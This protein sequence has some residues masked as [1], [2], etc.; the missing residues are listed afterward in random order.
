MG[1][2]VE[3]GTDPF[4]SRGAGM[5]RTP[6]R[7]SGWFYVSTNPSRSTIFSFNPNIQHAAN[8]M[9]A[10]R[11]SLSTTLKPGTQ[12]E[13]SLSP[14]LSITRHELGWVN[15]LVGVEAPHQPTSIF[16]ERAIDR[17]SMTLRFM[18]TLNPDLSIQ[19]YSQYIWARGHYSRFY[20]LREDGYL[21]NLPFTYD[22]DAYGN[23]DFNR[24]ALNINLVI[25]Y[26]YL[27]GSTLFLV[28]THSRDVFSDDV[29]RG[30]LG[31]ARETLT[32]PALNAFLIKVTYAF[33]L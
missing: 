20:R 9:Y 26:E 17:L 4:E 11:L 15:N 30:M 8:G 2:N 25:R 24:S 5:Y 27:P 21:E 22:R 31:F 18:H 1:L 32:A 19:W 10:Y 28:W 23:P 6:T 12:T 16:G 7:T 33:N 14:E 13:L 29:A 3:G